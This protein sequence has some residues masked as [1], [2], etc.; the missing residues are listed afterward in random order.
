MRQLART[1]LL[2]IWPALC[3]LGLSSTV[4][5]II[6][7]F[8]TYVPTSGLLGDSLPRVGAALRR[9]VL[10]HAAM[11]KTACGVPRRL[12]CTAQSI[13]PCMFLQLPAA[14][15]CLQKEGRTLHLSRSLVPL[16]A[17][18]LGPLQVLFFARIFA[19]V[20]GRFLPRLRPLAV[21]NPV[22]VLFLALAKFACE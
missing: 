4:A 14:S 21:S 3:A 6:F 22:I 18:A 1:A 11:H 17:C 9:A 15:A 20:L 8:F 7:P 12:A 5:L 10:C 2:R 19:D 16:S 13:Q